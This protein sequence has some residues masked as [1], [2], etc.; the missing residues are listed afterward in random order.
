MAEV[1]PKKERGTEVMLCILTGVLRCLLEM[2]KCPAHC[3]QCKSNM[4][5]CIDWIKECLYDSFS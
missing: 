1:S 5:D 3:Q 2:Q 4:E